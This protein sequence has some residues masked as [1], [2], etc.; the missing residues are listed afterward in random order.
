ML[1]SFRLG[2]RLLAAVVSISVTSPAFA[3]DVVHI[4]WAVGATAYEGLLRYIDGSQR[5]RVQ[6]FDGQ[7]RKLVEMVMRLESSPYGELLA[8]YN[9]IDVATGKR[10][11]YSA[12]NFLH[13]VE[14]DGTQ[15]LIAVDDQGVVAPSNGRSASGEEALK[16]I[17]A[18]DW[19]PMAM[20]CIG[21]EGFPQPVSFLV[22]WGENHNWEEVNVSQGRWSVQRHP[23][24]SDPPRLE[25]K[26]DA[27]ATADTRMVQMSVTAAITV[28]L[29][30]ERHATMYNLR[31]VGNVVQL[32]PQHGPQGS[33]TPGPRSTT[34]N[35]NYRQA[36]ATQL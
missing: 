9:P 11:N 16:L 26:F 14:P 33:S 7:Q 8:G 25:I 18:F 13:R 31:L 10:A 23:I 30:C 22:R 29:S 21:S 36:P 5:L 20:T 6:F 35:V 19:E 27:D 32:V 24:H 3:E 15:R 4:R 34:P 12:D 1:A 17:R 28:G 2:L